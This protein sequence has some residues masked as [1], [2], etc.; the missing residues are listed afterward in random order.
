MHHRQLAVIHAATFQRVQV[1]VKQH[2]SAHLEQG[3]A[4]QICPRRIG[5]V[6]YLTAY[7][8]KLN[9]ESEDGDGAHARGHPDKPHRQE[10]PVRHLSQMP[11][12][13]YD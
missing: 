6:L 11:Q 12:N 4:D 2:L 9:V 7:C 10:H 1:S 3:V 5:P 13:K 8:K